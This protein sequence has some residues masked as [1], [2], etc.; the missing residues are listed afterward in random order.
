W[1]QPGLCE[2]A[3]SLRRLW[4]IQTS[5]GAPSKQSC[6][7]IGVLCSCP[8]D[9]LNRMSSRKRVPYFVYAG[10]G[11]EPRRGGEPCAKGIPYC[12]FC[13]L[14]SS[15]LSAANGCRARTFRGS[16]RGQSNPLTSAVTS[17]KGRLN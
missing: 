8:E 11:L 2:E 16:G 9:V 10:A 14:Q 1:I 15:R 13:A 17:G 4:I 12:C 5:G 6:C 3:G 7:W